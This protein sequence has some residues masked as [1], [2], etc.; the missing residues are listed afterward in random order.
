MARYPEPIEEIRHVETVQTRG[1]RVT[2]VTIRLDNGRA[3]SFYELAM[4]GQILCCVSRQKAF[5]V[6]RQI[7]R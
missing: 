2:R 4:A 5:A 1:G 3:V 7:Q 6:I